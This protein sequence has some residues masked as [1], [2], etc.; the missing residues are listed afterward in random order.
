MSIPLLRSVE[1]SIAKKKVVSWFHCWWINLI[2]IICSKSLLEPTLI[3]WKVSKYG[4]EKTPYLDNFNAV[5]KIAEIM[6]A[7]LNAMLKDDEK[8]N[9]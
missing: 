9:I 3:A 1:F 4:L 7:R 6:V 8:K 2:K 5:A